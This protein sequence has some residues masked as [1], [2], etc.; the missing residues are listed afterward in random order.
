MKILVNGHE[1]VLKKNTS[2]QYE[3][4][5]PLFTEAEDYTM[6]I[7]FPL[8][9]C[10]ENILIFGALHVKGVDITTIH[11]PCEIIL[12]NIVK[13]GI[14]TIL[15]VNAEEVKGQFL[16]GMSVQNFRSSLPDTYI[17]DID[18]SDYDGTDHSS[19]SYERVFGEGW[20]NM[21]VWDSSKE[22]PIYF[23]Q[24]EPGAG[25][26]TCRHIYLYHLVRLVALKC[27]YTVDDSVLRTI[28]MYTKI[29]VVNTV[30]AILDRH[31]YESLP[32]LARSLPHW[33]VKEFFNEVC[34]FFGCLYEINSSGNKIVFISQKQLA[35]TDQGNSAN[36]VQ[37]DVLDDFEVE[38]RE[39]ESPTYRGNVKYKL[40]DESDPDKVNMCPWLV[41]K[42]HL[43]YLESKTEQAFSGKIQE[44]AWGY[45]QTI[46]DLMHKRTLFYLTDI[47]KYAVI[48]KYE[49][50]QTHDDYDADEE[51]HPEYL[52]CEFE[53]INQW[54]DFRD[55]E[56][57]GIAP[58]PLSYRSIGNKPNA[59]ASK[60]QNFIKT[61][62]RYKMP[63][64]EVPQDKY[65]EFR[66]NDQ[67]VLKELL[68]TMKDGED[69]ETV[70]F[71]KLWV[72]IHSGTMDQTGEY[73]NTRQYE[74]KAATAVSYASFFRNEWRFATAEDEEDPDE[75][76]TKYYPI[77]HQRVNVYPYNL[78]PSE[79]TIQAIAELPRVDETKLYRYKFLAS[80][81]PDP[82]KI[83]VIKGKEYACKKLTA[84]FTADGMSEL[85]QGE[86]FEVIS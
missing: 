79:A 42:Q 19:A 30:Y 25:G 47:D 64:I 70:Y 81:L 21:V 13:S 84:H 69:K 20:G 3:S 50:C 58:C 54:G 82:K 34:K 49:E 45:G 35:S 62:Y 75:V 18:F 76:G 86:F 65:I 24:G 48:T 16:E 63:S 51:G 11:F 60:S 39:S 9:D 71:E 73:L 57:L 43:Y 10:P 77:F 53:I 80:S 83:Y 14:L 26:W 5:N 36:R 31:G 74:A 7:S 46:E 8:E 44:A 78:V 6:D 1:A 23:M 72:V 85:I 2:F 4:E 61:G 41:E 17:T 22:A 15:S 29:I 68:E 38:L 67:V 55:G 40:P 59:D 28:P 37:L 27:G 12:G 52:F 66:N 56:E 33:T 32:S